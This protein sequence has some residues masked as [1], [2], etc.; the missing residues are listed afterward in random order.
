[1]KNLL[2]IGSLA[3][4]MACSPTVKMEAPKDPIVIDL[5]VKIE[6]NV[7]VQIERDLDSAIREKAEIF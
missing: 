3:L 4:C 2:G 1:M 5:N 6:H 7:R